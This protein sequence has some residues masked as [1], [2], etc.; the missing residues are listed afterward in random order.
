MEEKTVSTDVIASKSG[1]A[2]SK[3]KKRKGRWTGND[4]TLFCLA[5]LSVAFLAVFAYAPMFGLVLA[6]KD[7][8]G[9]LDVMR[10]IQYSDWVGFDNFREFLSEPDFKNIMVNTLGLNILQLCINF[11]CPIIFAVLTAELLSDKF[12][13]TV[14]TVTFFPYFISWAA[15]GG[16]FINLLDYDTNIFNT[17][18]YQAG[19]LKEKVNVLGDPDYF[20]G[21]IITTSLIKGMGWG[22]IIYVAAIAAIP[23]ELYEA[24]KIDGANRWHKIRYITL[25]SIAPTITLFF[26]LSVSGIL[27]NGIDHLLV[28]QNRSNISKSEVLD[29]FIY[30][31]G[32]KD[33]WY[34]WSYTSAVGIMKS[35][36]SLVLLISSNFICKKVT[37]KGIY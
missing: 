24:A 3:G 34:R 22:S 21:I 36:V 11:P 32:T 17:L 4:V 13:K 33:P 12:K 14:Q 35:I 23:Q 15:F 16:I 8:D 28:F 1:A 2:S 6:F 27:N 19:I 30:K 31:Y 7:G 37:G 5:L 25:P 20:W 26:I 18:L 29:T 9:Q 10:V